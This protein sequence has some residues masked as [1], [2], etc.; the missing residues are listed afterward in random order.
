MDTQLTKVSHPIRA[1][2]KHENGIVPN[3]R[4]PIPGH[5]GMERLAF[6]SE[7]LI[8]TRCDGKQLFYRISSPA[9]KVV[10]QT[11]YQQFRF[12]EAS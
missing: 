8:D 11:L 3:D 2:A 4:L 6:R 5:R 7:G 12:A 1:A 9:T 10:T